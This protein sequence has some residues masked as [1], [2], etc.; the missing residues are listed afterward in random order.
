M[1]HYVYLLEE[2]LELN[3]VGL[4]STNI[5]EQLVK[6]ITEL[7]YRECAAKVS[8][9]TGQSISAMG[10]W[11][12]IQQMGEKVCEEEA[13]LVEE[14]KKGHVQGKKEVPVLF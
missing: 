13:Q 5:S 11:N 4:I 8:E 1:K 12:V 2:T 3:R 14:Y 6:G 9:K 7:F 10:E